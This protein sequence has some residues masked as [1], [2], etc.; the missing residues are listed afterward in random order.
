MIVCSNCG[1][2]LEDNMNYCPL[3]GQPVERGTLPE[4]PPVEIA[5]SNESALKYASGHKLNKLQKRKL[6]WEVASLILLSGIVVVTLL[7]LILQQTISW[8]AYPIVLG[9]SLFAYFSLFTLW[10]RKRWLKLGVSFGISVVMLF[11]IDAIQGGIQWAGPVA[12]PLLAAAYLIGTTIYLFSRHTK[13]YGFLLI[14]NGFI[15]I[16]GFTLLIE[17]L[18]SWYRTQTISL[19]WSLILLI[20]VIPVASMLYYIHF[21]LKKQ[22]DL[23]KFFHI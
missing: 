11:A 14:A 7:N 10:V 17:G 8:A 15:G 13:Y 12:M 21:R 4:Q 18:L 2:A 16:A 19:E 9:L 3:C 5:N 22:P 20:S 23:R 1:V 6:I